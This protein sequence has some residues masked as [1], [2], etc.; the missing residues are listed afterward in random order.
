MCC[1]TCK[2]FD[3]TEPP[4]HKAAREAGNCEE[5][6]GKKWNC[7][8][9]FRFVQRHQDARLA[10]LCRFNPDPLKVWSW[11]AC[12]QHQPVL[13]PLANGWGITA[14]GQHRTTGG[15]Y[16]EQLSLTEWAAQ[17]FWAIKRKEGDQTYQDQRISDLETSNRLLR[18]QLASARKRSA[19][20]LA[21]LQKKPKPDKPQ[22][23]PLRLVAAE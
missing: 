7:F 16:N 19:S 14:F 12:A 23:Q 10:G 15:H 21:R 8:T 5:S 2:Y 18:N 11:H 17:Q 3:P 4:E 22:P 13:D 20:R 6:C 1:L 9:V